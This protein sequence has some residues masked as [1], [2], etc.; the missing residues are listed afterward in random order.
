MY[1]AFHPRIV[2][3]YIH[4]YPAED[5]MVDMLCTKKVQVGRR[6]FYKFVVPLGR[7]WASTIDHI[8]YVCYY[9]PHLDL[10]RV[11]ADYHLVSVRFLVFFVLPLHQMGR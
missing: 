10:C 11:Y 7:R 3:R 9:I 2:R 6:S 8:R 1:V 5:V 4:T